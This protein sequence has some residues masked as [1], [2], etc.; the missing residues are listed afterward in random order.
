MAWSKID[1]VHVTAT[2]PQKAARFFVRV[3]GGRITA[4]QGTPEFPMID[5]DL[6]GIPIRITK[7]T[8]ADENW[9]GLRIGLHHLG[10]Y[11][12]DLDRI[13]TEMKSTGAE[14]V[15]PVETVEPGVRY[16]FLK[17][18]EGVLMELTEDKNVKPDK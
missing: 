12:D 3:M 6:G 14:F 16:A 18:P 15:L 1:H 10:L 9:K 5:V 2:D 13:S 4:E 11:V 7:K 17:S 8:G